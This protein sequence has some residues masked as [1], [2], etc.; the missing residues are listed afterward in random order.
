M[1]GRYAIGCSSI[2]SMFRPSLTY[3]SSSLLPLV[4]DRVG[5][6][7]EP[8]AKV[9][10]C[11]QTPRSFTLED[12]VLGF[13]FPENLAA[14]ATGSK[15]AWTLNL[16]GVRNIYAAEGPEFA[17][18]RLTDYESDDGQELIHLAFSSD[19]RHL[20][21]VRGGNHAAQRSDPI[22]PP[23]PAGSAVQPKVEI[24]SIALSGGS[25]RLLGEGDAP[26]IA[27]RTARV[28]FLKDGR[29]WIG[30]IDGSTPPMRVT[31]QGISTSL[32]WSPDGSTL[33]FASDRDG[34]ASI[35]LFTALDRPI[36]Y[37]AASDARDSSPSWSPDGKLVAFD[38][39]AGVPVP[40]QNGARPWAIWVAGTDDG[41]SRQVWKSSDEFADSL[42]V[43]RDRPRFLWAAGNRILFLSSRDG[44]PHVHMVAAQ[45]G[46]LR[47]LTP[48]KFMV[49]DFAVAPDRRSIFYTANTGSD[50]DDGERRHL[51]RVAITLPEP[52]AAHE[53]EGHRVEPGA[54]RRR[55]DSRIS[56]IRGNGSAAPARASARRPPRPR[57]DGRP[58]RFS[59]AG[60]RPAGTCDVR[61]DWRGQYSRA[62]I[63][64]DDD[65]A[66]TGDRLSSRRTG[67][68]DAARLAL[69][70]LLRLRVCHQPVPR[71][72]RIRRPG[73]ELPAR[74]RLRPGVPVPGAGDGEGSGRV[75]RCR[76]GRGVPCRPG[77]MSTAPGSASGGCGTGGYL[78]SLALG[79]ASDL[80]A[81]G[82]DVHGVHDLV[83]AQIESAAGTEGSA[84]RFTWRSPVLLIH[85]DDDRNVPFSETVDFERLL[86]SKDV[87]V[88]TRVIPDDVHDF[89]RFASWRATA[90]AT[91]E[92]F[93]RRLAVTPA[94][95]VQR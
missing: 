43:I 73:G 70:R 64:S 41:S 55:K 59:G 50:P 44:W 93:E 62:A 42:P 91:V 65:R 71:E 22:E 30:P 68:A 13:P 63:Q 90:A 27:P 46:R 34:Q 60:S 83:L 74:H 57:S 76:C 78:T 17:A 21:F 12:Q 48:G 84:D 28:A 20:V 25:P 24:W 49:E 7:R 47:G 9:R 54:D 58:A 52:G 56:R 82:V 87:P 72:S 81:A 39:E 4:G 8:V 51:F 61:D 11:F 88:E 45:G 67:T 2:A 77:P 14:A 5:G 40:L 37:L 66:T 79:R 38:R 33:A 16:K 69:H 26:V 86:M 23:N 35:A 3:E 18:R 53:G 6:G 92:F 10:G 95:V 75:R 15:I 1:F 19:G 31:D 94:G 29:I 89:L 80:F 32:T 85:A 36:R